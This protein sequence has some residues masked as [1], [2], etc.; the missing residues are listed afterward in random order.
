MDRRRSRAS[1]TQLNRSGEAV[2]ALIGLDTLAPW[3]IVTYVK[4]P[5]ESG[6]DDHDNERTRAQDRAVA[7]T[8]ASRSG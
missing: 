5:A 3:F 2:R 6:K 4:I 7:S 8:R 1:R